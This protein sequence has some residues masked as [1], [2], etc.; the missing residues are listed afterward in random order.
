MLDVYAW[1]VCVRNIFHFTAAGM[2]EFGKVKRLVSYFD[3]SC[4]RTWSE[5]EP[6]FI[7]CL[8]A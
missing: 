1:E 4:F 8:T 7:M 2:V 6:Q 5:A 3:L